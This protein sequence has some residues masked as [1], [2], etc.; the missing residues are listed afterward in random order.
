MDGLFLNEVK[1]AITNLPDSPWKSASLADIQLTKI[2]G[3]LTN[4]LYKASLTDDFH[5]NAILVR[6]FGKSD[7]L[8]NRDS[9][10]TIFKQ[11]SDSELS[12][13]LLGI[14]E[15]GRL[16]EYLHK[17]HPLASGTDMIS[18]T[19]QRDTVRL[20]AGALA[21]LHRLKLSSFDD[22]QESY[23][24]GVIE[25]WLTLA[26]KYGDSIRLSPR[27]P[28]F[29]PPSIQ[30]F[31][32][33]C[34]FAES[35][36]KQKLLGNSS[37]RASSTC[38]RLLSRVLCHNDMLSGNIMLDPDTNSLRLIDFEYSGMNYAVAD[39]ANVFTAVCESIMLSGK[40]QDVRR[41]FPP[42]SIQ[43]HFLECYLGEPVPKEEVELVLILIQAFSM[44]D[45]LRWT[46]WGVIQANQSTVDFDYVFYYNS[47]FDAY[48]TY[49]SIFLERLALLE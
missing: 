22:L 31:R 47:R 26:V 25:R 6:V 16:E 15:W 9:E 32:E 33:E 39:I 40:P 29:H 44:L 13:R 2:T 46:I 14:Y 41:N 17:N 19:P 37:V 23:I 18:M 34:A 38:T 28:E 36:V 5:G 45:E 42:A 12:P 21:R 49:K 3:G 48:K 1:F 4:I 43:L 7:G 27:C 30:V 11:L 20:I 24:F 35:A 8:L 10:N